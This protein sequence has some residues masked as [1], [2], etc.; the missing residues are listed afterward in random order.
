MT[1]TVNTNATNGWSLWGSDSNTGLKSATQNYT[2]P[3][4][5]PGSNGS[6]SNG[7]EGYLTGLPAGGISQGGGAGTTAATTA[8]ASSGAGNGSGLDGTP[9]KIATSDGTAS[10]AVV[11]IEEYATVSGVTPAAADYSDTITIVGAGSF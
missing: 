5:T 8:Y 3:S 4:L 7:T 11:T 9:R 2:I 6:L 10:N 1:V